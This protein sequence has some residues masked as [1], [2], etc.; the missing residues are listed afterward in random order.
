M[1]VLALTTDTSILTS[2]SNDI[3]FETIFARQIEAY[4][5]KGAILIAI[6]TS[7][8][9]KNI[10][11]AVNA[12]KKKGMFVISLTGKSGGK[13]KDYCDLCL[14]AS[15]DETA[16]VQEMH[17]VIYHHLCELIENAFI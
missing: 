5:K 16:R 3:S 12:A 9:S 14:Q 11:E 7:G 13:I 17:V 2:W 1:N 6:T 4:G 8:H 10:L 15:S